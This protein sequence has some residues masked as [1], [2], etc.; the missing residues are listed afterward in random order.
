M[1]ILMLSLGGGGGNIL[2]SLKAMFR[3]DLATIQESDPHYAERLRRAV[4]TRFL[5]TNEFSVAD[6]AAEER[7]IIGAQTTGH[8]GSRHDPEVARRALEESKGD[9]EA[10]LRPH[11]VVILIGT[12]GK[13]TG[14]GTIV[15]I[16][17]M[18]RQ[19]RKLVIPIFVR[20]SFEWHEVEKR[21]YDHA[22]AV[23][24][25]FDAA[26]VRFIEILN[27]RG[28]SSANPQPQ[29]AVWERMNRPIA[30]G[31]RGLLYVLS[32]LSQVDPSDLSMLFAGPGRLRIGFAEVDPPAGGDPTDEQVQHA[33]GSC[34]E[35]PYSLFSKPVGTSLI[36]IQGQWSNVVDGRLKGGLAAL[37]TAGAAHATYNPLHAFAP[38]A[39]RPWGI[40]ALFAEYTGN[41]SPLEIDWPEVKPV[42]PLWFSTAAAD[43]AARI[44]VGTE[45]A[46][47]PPI[48]LAPLAAAEERH[49][50]AVVEVVESRPAETVMRTGSE[51]LVNPRS[52]STFW[53]FALAVNRKDASALAVA[54][55]GT[56]CDIPIEGSEVRKLLG[57]VWFRSVFRRLSVAWRNRLLDV[58]LDDTR[59]R[60][61][62]V[63]G[64]RR[65]V[66]LNQI[67]YEE[68]ERIATNPSVPDAVRA[69]VQ[70]LTAIGTVWGSD[71]LTRVRFEP[72][73]ELRRSRFDLLLQPFRH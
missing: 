10:L 60:N 70:L 20:P 61:H 38:A 59:I 5:D 73:E 68:L 23:S 71:A 45:A 52:F 67:S 37:A 18:A 35:N 62:I 56:T 12:G 66:R 32:D 1:T 8:L 29:H 42:R 14:A 43:K 31:L 15:P 30:R 58:L 19:Q 34:W 27:D 13:G 7:L 16:A 4:V 55:A 64:G 36:C 17:R 28:Y 65:A 33:V 3:R 46:V 51:T 26:G 69:D 2:R 53:D 49:P 39:P 54:A 63:R 41:H 47:A 50:V 11:T 40:T 72:V 9:V 22:L 6:I 57:T 44:G 48:P 21:R 25:Q 24:A